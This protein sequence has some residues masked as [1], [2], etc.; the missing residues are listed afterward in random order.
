MQNSH[1][2]SYIYLIWHICNWVNLFLASLISFFLCAILLVICSSPKNSFATYLIKIST[3]LNRLLLKVTMVLFI[4]ILK[5][6]DDNH[7]HHFSSIFC[8]CA[9]QYPSFSIII[10]ICSLCY[11]V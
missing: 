9:Y 4:V 2:Y 3:P 6:G 10:L 5:L 7:S 1:V 11:K 8:Q